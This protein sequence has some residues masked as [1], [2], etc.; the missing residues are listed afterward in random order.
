MTKRLRN[1]KS[2][3]PTNWHQKKYRNKMREIEKRTPHWFIKDKHEIVSKEYRPGRVQIS[4]IK[5][6]PV[7]IQHSQYDEITEPHRYL[8]YIK[9]PW[10]FIEKAFTYHPGYDF[11]GDYSVKEFINILDEIPEN[12]IPN[13]VKRYYK[14]TAYRIRRESS[15]YID[16]EDYNKLREK[17]HNEHHWY[18]GMVQ[19]AT[20]RTKLHSD[21]KKL[22]NAYNH[23]DDIKEHLSEDVE[24][25]YS[26]WEY[27]Y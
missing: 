12:V 19:T 20:G 27:K 23:D 18:S 22:A 15:P 3:K 14:H 24:R 25:D 9:S 17:V 8:L 16:R 26:D 11:T 7:V 4:L 21:L 1:P 10:G 5:E 13:H 2:P 6:L